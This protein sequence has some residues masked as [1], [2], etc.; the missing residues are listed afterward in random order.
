MSDIDHRIDDGLER[1]DGVGEVGEVLCEVGAYI[2]YDFLLFL[3]IHVCL[4]IS[5]NECLIKI[6]IS[7]HN[8]DYT[9]Q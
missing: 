7:G 1:M 5:I 8:K 3:V 2:G 6:L 4:I 9:A